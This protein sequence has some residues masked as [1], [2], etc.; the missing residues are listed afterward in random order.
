MNDSILR[1]WASFVDIV[2]NFLCDH[3]AENYKEFVEMLFKS[4]QNIGA[5]MNISVYLLYN[6][7]YKFLN[8][9]GIRVQGILRQ[10]MIAAYF[11]SIKRNLNNL[12]HDKKSRKRKIFP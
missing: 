8:N 5:Y 1:T 10:R 6:H 12:E 2:K 7:L 3:K 9:C 11:W 4:L